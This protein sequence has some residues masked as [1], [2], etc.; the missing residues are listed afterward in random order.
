M[1]GNE[2][3]DCSIK[4]R[5]STFDIMK[6]IAILLVVAGHC[7]LLPL[8]LRHAIFSFH[9]PLFFLLSGWLFKPTPD[10]LSSFTKN[11]KRLLLPFFFTAGILFLYSVLST[12]KNEDWHIL[13]DFF[14]ALLFPAGINHPWMWR[15]IPPTS[16][17]Y[18]WFLIALFWSKLT[19]DYLT[20]KK[21]P[22]W[23]IILIG[24]AATLLDSYVIDLPFGIL[25]GISA[26]VFLIIGFYFSKHIPRSWMLWMCVLCWPWAIIYSG[27]DM[28]YCHYHIYPLD[29]LGACGGT[30]FIWFL[31]SLFDKNFT[32]L[33]HVFGWL[34]RRSLVI[35]CIHSILKKCY[36]LEHFP[37]PEVWYVQL[38]LEITVILIVT[39]ICSFIPF[40]RTLFGIA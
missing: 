10:I 17:G 23:C 34:G 12:I 40:T 26:S 36:I 39:W 11:A 25:P 15:F 38:P 5:I 33:S 28:R 20:R 18:T 6:G 37:L 22:V 35:L 16:I 9:M 13:T 21:V 29:I 24:L 32:I 27:L 30:I 3:R 8:Y 1:V 14:R 4:E 2:L 31:S 19:V 7:S